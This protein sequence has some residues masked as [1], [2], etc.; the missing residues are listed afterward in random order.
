MFTVTR[1]VDTLVDQVSLDDVH[2]LQH[3]VDQILEEVL[4]VYVQQCLR[5]L[6][7][8]TYSIVL[9][10]IVLVGESRRV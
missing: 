8:L 7:I 4:V 2:G 1:F 5:V 3:R 6:S 10:L 9:G